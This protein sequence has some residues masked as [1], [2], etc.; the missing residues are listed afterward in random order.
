MHRNNPSGR[1]N[2]E[3]FHTAQSY[4]IAQIAVTGR[5]FK[6]IFIIRFN[7]ETIKNPK[8]WTGTKKRGKESHAS[9][10]GYTQHLSAKHSLLSDS[11]THTAH[12]HTRFRDLG[13]FT[14]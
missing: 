2:A 14:H 8:R 3:V 5:F 6:I 11:L 12:I 7:F 4:L 13:F 9:W 10:N 1:E